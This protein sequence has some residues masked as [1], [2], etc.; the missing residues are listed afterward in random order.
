VQELP[1]ELV[2]SNRKTLVLTVD[3]EARLVVRAPM[4]LGENVIRDFV[5]KK[6]RWAADKQRQITEFR[7]SPFVLDN[8]GN[9][10]YLGNSYTVLRGGVSE[11]TLEGSFIKIPDSMTLKG[12]AGWM[13]SQSKPLIRARV[14]YYANLMGVRYTSVKLSEARRRWGSCGSGNTLNFAWRLVMCPQSAIDYVAVH[15]LS[16]ITYKN[17]GAKFWA[18]VAAIIPNYE[19]AQDWLRRNSR[20]MDTI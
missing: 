10:R 16:H 19:E 17:H 2:R 18:R 1:Y 13:K 7:A 20:L 8:G 11:V 3:R 15:E 9:V 5:R 6:A 12:F 4:K 14:D